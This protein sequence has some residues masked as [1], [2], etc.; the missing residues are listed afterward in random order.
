MGRS[1]LFASLYMAVYIKNRV[2]RIIIP[3]ALLGVGLAGAGASTR[4][5][6]ELNRDKNEVYVVQKKLWGLSS[7]RTLLR[8]TSP[9]WGGPA[10]W[11]FR[12][13]N[14]WRPFYTDGGEWHG[15][16]EGQGR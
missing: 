10:E 2:A 8:F 13:G 12:F 1:L 5:V 14:E 7:N 9:T 16:T 3:L 6:I 11:C 4:T 15:D